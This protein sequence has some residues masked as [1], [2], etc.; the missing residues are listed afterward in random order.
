LQALGV[1]RGPSLQ[2]LSVDPLPGQSAADAEPGVFPAS[3]TFM[4]CLWEEARK[5][6]LDFWP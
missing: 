2:A 5:P 1:S 3:S 6:A 4:A